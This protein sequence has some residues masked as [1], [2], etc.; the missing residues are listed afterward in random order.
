[1]KKADLTPDDISLFIP[2][3]ANERIIEALT[4]RLKIDPSKVYK[5]IEYYGNTSAASVPLALD[6]ANREGKIKKGDYVMMA[7]FGSGLIWGAALVKW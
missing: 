1:L 2:H 5:N 4:K 6:E 7:A 3:Q